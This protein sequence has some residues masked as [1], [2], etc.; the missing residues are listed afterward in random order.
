MRVQ[1]LF[2]SLSPSPDKRYDPLCSFFFLFLFLWF[3]YNE[4]TSFI[5]QI[6]TFPECEHSINIYLYM[7]TKYKKSICSSHWMYSSENNPKRLVS[8]IDVIFEW[9]TPAT[10][11]WTLDY[12]GVHSIELVVS[13]IR[14]ADCCH[15]MK[16]L[17][18]IFSSFHSPGGKHL[19]VYA[20]LLL[21]RW[22]MFY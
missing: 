11:E 17:N 4:Q 16:M 22:C 18:H 15:R 9:L 8:S 2:L 21:L 1:A 13:L 12:F 3:V 10:I 7:C 14:K 6:S 19:C 5:S 20:L